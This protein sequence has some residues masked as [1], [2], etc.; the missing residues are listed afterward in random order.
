MGKL[1]LLIILTILISHLTV[2]A[3]TNPSCSIGYAMIAEGGDS[4]A[5]N[6]EEKFPMMSVFK[7]HQAVALLHLFEQTGQSIDSIV[8]IPRAELNPLTWSPMLKENPDS[9]IR[10]PIR[11]LLTYTLTQSDNNASN[12][13]FDHIQSVNDADSYIAALIPR[14]SFRMEV[15][16]NQMFE[17]HA[18]A[19]RNY[20]SPS[21]AAKLIKT[22]FTDSILNPQHSEFLQ[23]TLRECQTGSDRIS[24]AFADI[25]GVKIAHKT[26]SGFRDENGLLTAHND[27]ALIELPNGRR[28][29]IAIFV[30]DFDGCDEEASGLIRR[31]AAEMRLRAR[32]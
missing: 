7:L 20:S 9:I 18:L 21:G 1:N 15:T 16:E 23:S 6:D 31:I 30:K 10:L 5:V 2:R 28:I 24:E 32:I 13:L 22:L 12:Y 3:Q 29:A 25:P 8:E 14:S 27:V 4:L 19:A 26:G 11:R 17:N